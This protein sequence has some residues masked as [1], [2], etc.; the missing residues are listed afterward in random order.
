MTKVFNTTLLRSRRLSVNIVTYHEGHRVLQHNDP[1]GSGRYFKFNM[2]LIKP[3]KGGN[4]SCEKVIFS[5]FDRIF[6]FRPDKYLHSVS[7]IEKGKRKL[8]SVAMY[9]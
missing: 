4:F 9:I 6:F 7:K 1:M 8:L 2:V 5:L 3:T